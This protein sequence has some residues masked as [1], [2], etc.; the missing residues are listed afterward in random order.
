MRIGFQGEPDATQGQ[1]V[2]CLIFGCL[3][4]CLG[5]KPAEPLAGGRQK[6]DIGILMTK[7]GVDVGHRRCAPV[8]W[9][10]A[11]VE[12]HILFAVKQ[13][14]ARPWHSGQAGEVANGGGIDIDATEAAEVGFQIAKPW[15]RPVEAARS[16]A[17]PTENM[18]VLDRP[19]IRC[20]DV[21]GMGP[22]C[23][24]GVEGADCGG[25]GDEA[26]GGIRTFLSPS[27]EGEV[28]DAAGVEICPFDLAGLVEGA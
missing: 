20:A 6:E 19:E 21:H 18:G 3:A 13:I 28:P 17:D 15:R 9:R 25:L 12:C 10:F 4:F 2:E 22:H 24:F 1:A 5:E 16:A 26:R 11:T 7:C 8:V 14:E 23:R 27:G